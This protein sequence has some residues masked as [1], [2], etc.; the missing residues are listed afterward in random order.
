MEAVKP[1]GRDELV[2]RGPETVNAD[3]R[4]GVWRVVGAKDLSFVSVGED[5][6]G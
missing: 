1:A 4:D 5:E 3:A 6:K 2:L